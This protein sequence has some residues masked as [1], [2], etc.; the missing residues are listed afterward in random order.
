[1]HKTEKIAPAIP[2]VLVA[3]HVDSV[4]QRGTYSLPSLKWRGSSVCVVGL[5]S[6]RTKGDLREE[7][8]KERTGKMGEI[9]IIIISWN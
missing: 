7:K 6:K 2:Q 1:M 3:L 9:I 8:K 5:W 4:V